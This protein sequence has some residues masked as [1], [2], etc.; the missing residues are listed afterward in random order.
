[1]LALTNI[2]QITMNSGSVGSDKPSSLPVPVCSLFS[3][4]LA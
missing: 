4:M 3:A 1:M 2:K